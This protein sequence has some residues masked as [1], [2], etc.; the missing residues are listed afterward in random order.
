MRELFWTLLH[1]PRST[2]SFLTIHRRK[3]FIRFAA[4]PDEG[5]GKM[6][7]S[8]R[9]ENERLQLLKIARSSFEKPIIACFIVASERWCWLKRDSMVP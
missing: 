5:E 2:R 6:K 9:S 8:V 3:R 1:I 7:R 4:Q